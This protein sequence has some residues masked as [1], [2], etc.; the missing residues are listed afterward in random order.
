MKAIERRITNDLR[1]RD[2]VPLVAITFS[3]TWGVFALYVLAPENVLS[4]LG[5]LNGKHPLFYLAVY[6]PAIAAIAVILTRSGVTGLRR[7]CGR[8]NFWGLSK[9][10]TLFVVL[11]V[12]LPFF[13]G[14]IVQGGWGSPAMGS[15]GSVLAA[16]LLMLIKGPVEEIGWRGAVL[17]LL[18]RRMKPLLAA[19]VV[20]VIWGLWHLPAFLLSGTPQSSWNFGAFFCGTLALS[21]IVTALYNRSR[22]SLWVAVFFHFQMNNPLWPD[23]QPCDTVFFLLLA[24]VV[25]AVEWQSMWNG[26]GAVTDVILSGPEERRSER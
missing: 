25:I 23:G 10:W 14:A 5:E 16:M 1:I 8:F 7:F 3:I 22:G 13:L 20:G 21:V 19:L 4:H 26:Q 15:L 24:V 9:G 11:I 6:A 12:P 18:Q 2:L 17:P